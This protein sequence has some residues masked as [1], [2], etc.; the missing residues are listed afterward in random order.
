M[1]FFLRRECFRF[2]RSAC[3]NDFDSEKLRLC[4]SVIC[5]L[6]VNV[7]IALS[8]LCIIAL[9]QVSPW[10][11][12]LK[13]VRDSRY[14]HEHALLF[15]F[16]A[17]Y[18]WG[19]QSVYVFVSAAWLR[20][21]FCHRSVIHHGKRIYLVWFQKTLSLVSNRANTKPILMAVQ[22]L[23]TTGT[24][25]QTHLTLARLDTKVSVF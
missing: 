15:I 10:I 19:S 23:G 13:S 4:D 3:L 8:K 2:G 22:T 16:T 14:A 25:G 21:R 18:K 7:L 17:F 12:L 1:A 6:C 20:Q 11:W 5:R 9:C 24:G